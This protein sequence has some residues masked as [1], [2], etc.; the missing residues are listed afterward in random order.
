M[1]H[2][3]FEADPGV[4]CPTMVDLFQRIDDEEYE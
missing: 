4:V 3:A 1:L 2:G